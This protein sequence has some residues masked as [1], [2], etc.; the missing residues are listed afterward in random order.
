M[1][2]AGR[3]AGGEVVIDASASSQ[4]VSGLLLAA[5][6]FDRGIVVRHVGPPVPSPRRTCG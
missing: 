6:R 2:G 1:H 3:V 4:L 5:P